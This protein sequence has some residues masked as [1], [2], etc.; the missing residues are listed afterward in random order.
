MGQG[1]HRVK[2]ENTAFPTPVWCAMGQGNKKN[3]F[4]VYN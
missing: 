2:S 3:Q 1:S 4:E